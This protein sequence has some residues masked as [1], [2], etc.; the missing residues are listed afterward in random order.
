MELQEVIKTIFKVLPQHFDVTPEGEYVNFRYMGENGEGY[1]EFS[2]CTI[3]IT[4]QPNG[5]YIDYY[6]EDDYVIDITSNVGDQLIFPDKIESEFHLVLLLTDWFTESVGTYSL[7]IYD[8]EDDINKC[9]SQLSI[10]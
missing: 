1:I 3:R 5:L 10:K 7:F 4:I 2:E 8:Q 6:C 9:F